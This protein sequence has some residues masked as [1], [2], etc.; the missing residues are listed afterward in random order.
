MDDCSGKATQGMRI[1][2]CA[3][4]YVCNECAH[5]FLRRVSNGYSTYKNMRCA[6]CK[7]KFTRNTKYFNLVKL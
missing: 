3:F 4:H 7:Q 1:H 6:T 2:G 5:L